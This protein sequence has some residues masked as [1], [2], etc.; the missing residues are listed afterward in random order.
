MTTNYV[1]IERIIEEVNRVKIPN[2]YWNIDE[3]KEWTYRA[4]SFIDT[5]L[6]NIKASTIIE[7]IDNKGL[8]PPNLEIVDKVILEEAS[9]DKELHKI[10]PTEELNNN[11]YDVNTGYIYVNFAEGK[12]TL[13]YFTTPVDDQGRPLIPDDV[14]YI[15][16]VVSFIR[17]RL[18]ERAYWQNKI[19]ERQLNMLETDWYFYLPAARAN[20]KMNILRDSKRFR[21][22][23][24]RHFF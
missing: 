8:I 14:Y 13:N 4:L 15:K 7:I 1:G 17:Y 23:S 5:K 10:L 21:K 19:L 11:N 2:T 22:I 6:A 20:N 9:G 3:I 12:V 24:N 18:G 16:A